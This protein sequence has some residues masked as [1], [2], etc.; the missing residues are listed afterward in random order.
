MAAAQQQPPSRLWADKYKP[1]SVAAMCYPV[2]ANKLKQWL[3]AFDPTN[4][5]QLRGALLSGPPGVGKTTTVYLVAQ[6]LNL[7]VIEYNASDFR[8]KKSLKENVSDMTRNR[9]FSRSS[10]SVG[11][12]TGGGGG[13]M[14]TRF[15]LLMDEVDGCDLG[16]V[17]Q[18]IEMIKTTKIPI[19]CTC[20]DR[21]HQKLRSL[22]N[23]VED[24]R[25]SRPP[26]NIVAN[27]ICDVVLAR[28]RVSL[29]KPVLQD[30]IKQCG[31]DIRNVLNNLQVWCMKRNVLDAQSLISCAARSE[32]NS[33][34]G[35]FDAAEAFLLR[36]DPPKSFQELQNAFYEQN[37]T[38]L[39]VQ[40]NY[41][42]F[43]PDG[44]DY[45]SAVTS[46]AKS[47]SAADGVKASMFTNQ[48]WMTSNA[49]LL[50]SCMIPC[51]LTRGHY[52]SFV[53]PAQQGFDRSRPVKFPVWLGNNSTAS[54]NARILAVITKEGTH[55][56]SG[57]SGARE[58]VALDYIPL[59]LSVALAKPL[60][61]K[62]KE[63]IEAVVA[64]MD[65]YSLL[66]DDWDFVTE[67]RKFKRLEHQAQIPHFGDRIATAV[68]SAFTREFNK[69]HKMDSFARTV[70]SSGA[71]AAGGAAGVDVAVDEEG[72]ARVIAPEDQ[73]EAEDDENEE[74]GEGNGHMSPKMA[75]TPAL[76]TPG[77]KAPPKP[78]A[79]KTKTPTPPGGTP[80][81]KAPQKRKADGGEVVIL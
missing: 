45:M 15:V 33:D 57:F 50:L 44:R 63:G 23:H 46:A 9:V 62:E 80:G 13:E 60:V 25:F 58:D 51:S 7:S 5:K 17:G 8:S 64:V 27:Y 59:G 69:T 10:A 73:A 54:K 55:P 53:P 24:V 3:Q 14:S 36:S 29:P 39:F 21:W 52:V 35:V 56:A 11:G 61:E 67:I 66:R 12:V 16:G 34:V 19:L 75:K 76:A 37:L 31:S 42:R 18:V 2:Y 28:E 40:E 49:H 70:A 26:C 41:L 72:E 6:E 68:K 81:K 38:D 79:A 65:N 78:S 30:I 22:M 20:N 71:K 48:N 32:K 47:I 74:T 77:K 43:R 4:P 1:R